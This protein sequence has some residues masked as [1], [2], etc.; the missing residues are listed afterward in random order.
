MKKYFLSVILSAILIVPAYAVL[1]E[2][3][4]EQTICVLLSELMQFREQQIGNTNAFNELYKQ[5][6]K[7]MLGVM[8]KADQT[9]LILY[10]QQSDY[11]F[12]LTYACHEATQQYKDFKLNVMPYSQW[13]KRVNIEIVRYDAL[14]KS[15]ENMP[16]MLL[17]EHHLGDRDSCLLLATAIRDQM[18]K[19]RGKILQLQ[20]RHDRVEKRLKELNDYAKI[21]YSNIRTN[22]FINGGD[23][24]LTILK[25]LSSKYR[26]A[27]SAISV[28][29]KPTHD[30][31][32]D[33]RGPIILFLFAFIF[34]W[35]LIA[36]AVSYGVVNWLYPHEKQDKLYVER[37]PCM[38]WTLTVFT[39]SIAVL[40]IR[41][42]WSNHGFFQM[43]TELLIQYAIL[44]GA[45]LT[46]L[47]IRMWNS[48]N[49]IKRG[50]KIYL[51]MFFL[52]FIVIAFRI[53]FIPN[54]TVNLIFPPIL[55]FC[56]IW[57]YAAIYRHNNTDDG[58]ISKWDYLYAYLSLIVIAICTICSWEGYTLMAVQIL[59]WWY[60][61]LTCIQAITCIYTLLHIYQR[62][63]LEKHSKAY[64][65]D[66]KKND[67]SII[68]IK[69]ANGKDSIK[70]DITRTWFYDFIYKAFIPIL[71]VFSVMFCVY[72]SAK[73][74]DLSE[75]VVGIFLQNLVDIQ[76]TIRI[77]L[78]AISFILAM[79]FL[80]KYGLYLGR[81][82]YLRQH[83]ISHGETN[84]VALGMNIVTIVVWGFYLIIVMK[85]LRIDNTGIIAVL[86]GMSTGIGLA[87]KD[88]IENLFYGISLM[89][90][91]VKVGDV[92]EL[93][94]IRGNISN[95]N[96]Q[97]TMVET[98]DG[99]IIAFQNSQLF[100]KNFKNLTKNHG[101]ELVKIPIGIAYGTNVEKVRKILFESIGKLDCFNQKRGLQILFDN[102]GDNS[103]DLIL[104]CWVPVSKKLSAVAQIKEVIYKV[105]NEN[106]IEIPFPQRDIY[107]R[108]LPTN[109]QGTIDIA[110]PN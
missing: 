86:A 110:N 58:K 55:I 70:L 94:G 109:P 75:I 8:Q 28:K 89:T 46:S 18:Y 60:M 5:M 96:Y 20:D 41:E 66:G 61:Q 82:I 49:R 33:W 68:R 69:G 88:L 50:I 100:T 78:W 32:S 103:V 101:N 25:Q 47:L 40:I 102:F 36:S 83:R 43:A 108:Q 106:N 2:K 87:M 34:L 7:Q 39:F 35:M 3:D 84:V 57:Q 65:E 79:F 12:D 45:I 30:A 9:S 91:R 31:K 67:N 53:I 99:S 38:I 48:P 54:E 105:F 81:E 26:Q 16:D 64:F 107:V 14:I 62:W 42:F 52:G 85:I 77:S 6:D 10:S 59:I 44:M 51:P 19:N 17:D 72:W 37:R 4:L 93:D 13:V 98:L 74:F 15:L 29:Y 24:Y 22:I 56:L 73:V 90:G 21:R 76:G 23:N 92:I 63:K 104:V 71:A 97:C 11:I 27:I 95:I 80:V 1:K